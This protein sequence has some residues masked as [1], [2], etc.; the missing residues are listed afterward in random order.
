MSHQSVLSFNP[1]RDLRTSHRKEKHFMGELALIDLDAGSVV[2]V[3]RT[4]GTSTG[5]SNT[6][7]LWVWHGDK[8]A[9]SSGHAGGY[10]Y[11][12]PSA[13]A[14][15]AFKA[16]G[17]VLERDIAGVGDTAMEDAMRALAVHLGIAR[18]LIHRA[19]P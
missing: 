9:N 8:N 18:P 5:G 12:R 2:A 14:A 10:G 3:L 15:E 16:A 13:A 1:T 11:H 6:C 17:F 19:N 4:Y 7:C